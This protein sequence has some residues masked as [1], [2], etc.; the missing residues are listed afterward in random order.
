MFKRVLDVTSGVYPTGKVRR[1]LPQ[2]T[3]GSM[4]FNLRGKNNIPIPFRALKFCMYVT[5]GCKF[6][7]ALHPWG[8]GCY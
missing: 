8:I 3:Y 4:G 1:W 2:I 7:K 6:I 5:Y